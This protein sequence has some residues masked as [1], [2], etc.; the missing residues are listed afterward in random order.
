MYEFKRIRIESN[1]KNSMNWIV[2][3]NLIPFLS[4]DKNEKR[5]ENVVWNK[6][7]N[8]IFICDLWYNNNL[9]DN[10]W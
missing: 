3:V 8:N 4:V 9:L 6:S 5:Q 10:V 2:V 1:R 7:S